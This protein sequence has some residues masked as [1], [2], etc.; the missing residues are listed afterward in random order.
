MLQTE[1]EFI[2]RVGATEFDDLFVRRGLFADLLEEETIFVGEVRAESVVEYLDDFGQRYFLILGLART[3][4]C[5]AF[6]AF[7]KLISPE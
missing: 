1:L 6:Y 2:E 5:R 3:N 4:V 7:G